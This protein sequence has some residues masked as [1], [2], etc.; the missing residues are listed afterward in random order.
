M[1]DEKYLIRMP[2][3]KQITRLSESQIHSL[4]LLGKP[5]ES[6]PKKQY[7]YNRSYFLKQWT[8]Y[9]KLRDP[10]DS[11]ISLA[12]MKK[13]TRM[14]YSKLKHVFS[15]IDI[16]KKFGSFRYYNK[17]DFFEEYENYKKKSRYQRNVDKN[18]PFVEFMSGK[19]DRSELL[20]AYQLKK[21]ASRISKPIT[22][23]IQI[24]D[25]FDEPPKKR[26]PAKG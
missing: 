2:E 19:F 3:A 4:K 22:H 8:A 25:E 14:D 9:Q 1:L 12:E 7:Y 24:F 26:K 23:L 18:N 21:M 17:K 15:N 20:Q 16:V 5:V 11:M 13:I 10:D 6:L